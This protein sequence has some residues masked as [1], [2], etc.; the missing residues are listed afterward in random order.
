M[1]AFF[2]QTFWQASS[3]DVWKAAIAM[4]FVT[5]VAGGVLAWVYWLNRK[6]VRAV[7]EPRRQELAVMLNSLSG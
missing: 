5:V 4:S 3:G 7:L 2:A 1:L 6:A